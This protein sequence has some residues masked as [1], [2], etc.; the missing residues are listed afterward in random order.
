MMER[1]ALRGKSWVV[2]ILIL[3]G[4]LGQAALAQEVKVGFVNV[5]KV[6]DKSPQAADARERI[7]K[8]FAPK[9]RALLA[10]QKELRSLEDQLVRDQA[11]M[12]EEQRIQA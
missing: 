2:A 12:T 7:E 1:I 5:A 6:L 9:D 3:A 11:V 4:L 10:Q 8:E